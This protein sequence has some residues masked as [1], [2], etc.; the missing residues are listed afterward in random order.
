MSSSLAPITDQTFFDRVEVDGQV[1]R[2]VV[3][4]GAE[5]VYRGGVM[6]GFDRCR[7]LDVTFTFEGAAGETVGFMRALAGASPDLRQVMRDMLPELA[8]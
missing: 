5:L 6:P 3:F 2:Q 4:D 8:D 1:F 7:F